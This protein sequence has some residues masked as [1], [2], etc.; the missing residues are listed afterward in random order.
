MTDTICIPDQAVQELGLLDAYLLCLIRRSGRLQESIPTLARQTSIGRNRL[1]RALHRLVR[2]GLVANLTPTL[3]HR[4]HT[5]EL[6]RRGLGLPFWDSQNRTPNSSSTTTTTTLNVENPPDQEVAVVRV[7]EIGV[8]KR[9]PSKRK[10]LPDEQMTLI[11]EDHNQNLGALDIQAQ[12]HLARLGINANLCQRFDTAPDLIREHTPAQILMFHDAD[13]A[14][15][16]NL[17]RWREA[18]D[19]GALITAR[20][21]LIWAKVVEG[22]QP[23]EAAAEK[24]TEWWR[25]KAII[26]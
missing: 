26:R 7:P 5:Y 21:A 1:R 24:E 3:Q 14:I 13:G 6:S 22:Q 16:A 11:E 25:D 10:K 18:W 2:T 20:P 12:Q 4:P 19:N 17:A 9:E 8:P 15:A 23:P